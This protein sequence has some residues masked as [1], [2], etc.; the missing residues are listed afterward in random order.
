MAQGW[1]ARHMGSFIILPLFSSFHN[2]YNKHVLY[3]YDGKIC[4]VFCKRVRIKL[5]SRHIISL[6]W[7]S[8]STSHWISVDLL[9]AVQAWKTFISL[10]RHKKRITGLGFE[11]SVTA[12]PPTHT[13]HQ[14]TPLAGVLL[15]PKLALSGADRGWAPVWDEATLYLTWWLLGWAGKLP[16][17]KMAILRQVPTNTFPRGQAGKSQ[18]RIMSYIHSWPAVLKQDG[19]TVSTD[20]SEQMPPWVAWA[21]ASGQKAVYTEDP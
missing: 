19:E 2:L 6:Y 13:C 4:F 8:F 7:P 1:M 16:T 10:Q 5:L 15:M 20:K 11:H 17:S 14:S 21:C 18:I 12:N 3:L 9:V